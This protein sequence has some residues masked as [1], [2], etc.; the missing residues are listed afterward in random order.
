MESGRYSDTIAAIATAV[1]NSGIGI[2]RI[3]GSKAIVVADRIFE[4][5]KEGKK[6]QDVPTHTIHYGMVKDGNQILDEV[7]VTVMRGPHSYTGEDTVEINCHGGVLVMKRILETVI[8]SGAVAAEPG[9]FT[10]RAFLNGRMDLSQAEAVMDV[11]AAKNDYAMANSVSQL[12]GSVSR[13]IKKL[14]EALLYQVAYIES[15]LDDPEHISLDGYTRELRKAL[16]EIVPEIE[17]LLKNADNGRLISEGIRTVILGKPNAGKSSLMNILVGQERAIVTDVAG[18]TR[19]IL[20]EQIRIG[21]VSLRLTDTAGIRETEDVVEKI[22]V[23][24]AKEAAKEADLIIYVVDGACPLDGNDREIIE[25]L[26]SKRAIILLNKVDL[27][28]VVEAK[29]LE[30]MTGHP[31]IEISAKEEIGI[32]RLEKEI[33]Y[34]FFH[35]KLDFNDELVITNIRHKNALEAALGSLQLVFQ[36]MKDGMPEDFLTIDLMDAYGK[37]GSIVGEA[38]EDDLV[39]EIFGKFCMGK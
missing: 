36:G 19:D 11:I 29:E 10:K 6:L 18:T 31:V 34:L 21:D 3:S 33:S 7:L 37:L 39:N 4:S 23:L 38:V 35:G 1:S 28:L 32:E 25:M 13:K 22:G 2:I 12:K 17:G 30:K 20:E 26:K 15:A 8:R 9:E 16:E 27:N 5:I 24:R 14:R